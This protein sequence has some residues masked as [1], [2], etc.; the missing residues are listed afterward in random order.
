MKCRFFLL[1]AT[2]SIFFGQWIPT[3]VFWLCRKK[4]NNKKKHDFL[5]V[6]GKKVLHIF[7]SEKKKEIERKE[8]ILI[9]MVI[10][11]VNTLFTLDVFWQNRP[12]FQS[13]F[14]MSLTLSTILSF[15]M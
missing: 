1:G 13:A 2:L 15:E 7:M 6:G 3:R 12:N 9:K 14:A 8:S 4:K 5:F 10:Y 11:S